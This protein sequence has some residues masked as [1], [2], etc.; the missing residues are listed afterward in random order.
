MVINHLLNG[1]ILQVA[2]KNGWLEYYFPIGFRPIFR[3]ELLVSGRVTPQKNEGCGCPMEYQNWP[4]N[5]SEVSNPQQSFY[6]L[7]DLARAGMAVRDT[8]GVARWSQKITWYIMICTP[9]N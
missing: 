7:I 6:A 4:P 5:L 8:Q 9:E 3:G 2:P 1:M